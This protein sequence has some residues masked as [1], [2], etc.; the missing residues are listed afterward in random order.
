MI[1]ICE[2]GYDFEGST[3]VAVSTDY[4][5]VKQFAENLAN[6]EKLES[7]SCDSWFDGYQYVQITSLEDLKDIK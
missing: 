3:I 5:L 4:K 2:H 6:K 7:S 1:Y